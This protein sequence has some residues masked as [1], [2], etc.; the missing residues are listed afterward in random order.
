[1][2]PK[3]KDKEIP[4]EKESTEPTASG[5]GTTPEESRRREIAD[6]TKS[7][8]SQ[9]AA[10]EERAER[11][12]EANQRLLE[13]QSEILNKF[14]EKEMNQSM[15]SANSSTASVPMAGVVTANDDIAGL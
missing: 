13:R 10:L 15:V 5:S 3:A 4:K 2:P 1:M 9:I 11:R 6:L 8:Q 7:F 12:D 14:A